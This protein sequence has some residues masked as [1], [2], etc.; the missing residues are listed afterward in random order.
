[1]VS[2]FRTDSQTEVRSIQ[3][4][5][6]MNPGSS[7]GPLVNL[8]GEVVGINS[9][10]IKVSGGIPVE[11]VNF[12]VAIDGIKDVLP[13]LMAG[14]DI[15]APVE[16]SWETYSNMA[17]GYS[18]SY[19]SSWQVDDQNLKYVRIHHSSYDVGLDI[20]TVTDVSPKSKVENLVDT[21][22]D[23]LE[24]DYP[25]FNLLY[26]E[27]VAYGG[28]SGIEIA[29][30]YTEGARWYFRHFFARAGNSMYHTRIWIKQSEYE[31]YSVT[32]DRIISSFSL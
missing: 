6:A 23:K 25:D 3:T 26:R 11:G 10:V 4:D 12:A 13:Q 30:T 22:I 2:A 8:S 20:A 32:I 9:W 29:Y 1:M 5:A 24:G 7:G 21:N 14:E 18:I 16:E 17:Y 27:E 15:L 19:P 31:S 28:L